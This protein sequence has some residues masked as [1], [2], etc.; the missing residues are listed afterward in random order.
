MFI[1]DYPQLVDRIM[2]TSAENTQLS[3]TYKSPMGIKQDQNLKEQDKLLEDEDLKALRGRNSFVDDVLNQHFSERPLSDKQIDALREAKESTLEEFSSLEEYVRVRNFENALKGV[4]ETLKRND[5]HEG[6]WTGND[7]HDGH[8]DAFLDILQQL[9][10]SD[11][12]PALSEKQR[13]YA[14]SIIENYKQKVKRYYLKNPHHLPE[15]ERVRD[16]LTY[17]EGAV[18]LQ[19]YHETSRIGSGR[20]WGDWE[21]LEYHE[22]KEEA[23]EA[24]VKYYEGS[25][26]DEKQLFVRDVEDYY[27]E[28]GLSRA[29]RRA[30]RTLLKALKEDEDTTLYG[31]INQ[32]IDEITDKGDEE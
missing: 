15:N 29:N 3:D 22:S 30:I 14:L 7:D 18:I 26:L 28:N 25:R 9:R 32:N 12:T 13:E 16:V 23:K 17:D 11:R 24:A 6:F 21:Y 5:I 10:N 27:E 2:T 31:S 4:M 8:R 20:K 1:K 19:R